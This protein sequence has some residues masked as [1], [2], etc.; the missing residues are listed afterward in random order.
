[1]RIAFTIILN[2]IHHLKH[3][4]YAEFLLDTF[5]YWIVV[6][7]GSDS[8]GDTSWCNKGV[9][10]QYCKDGGSIDGTREYLLEL[11]RKHKNL[12]LTLAPG[13]LWQN[14]TK[15][16]NV[17]AGVI[18]NITDHAFVWEIDADE[19]WTEPDIIAAEKS[20]LAQGAKTGTFL[21]NCFVGKNLL[22]LGE[23]GEGTGDPI[24]R[25]WDWRR[26]T[27]FSHEPPILTGGNGK[28]VLL[29]QR[30]D[31]YS[32]YFEKDVQFKNDWYTGH[33]NILEYWKQ[34]QKE[35][36]FPQ[37]ISRLIEGHWG[38]TKT[39]IYRRKNCG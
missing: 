14:K 38:K 30:F 27:F 4:D 6:E 22:A 8:T 32:Y 16:V 7:G 34:L 28:T 5:D 12:L 26:N 35:T 33:E 2:G 24:R 23:W 19:Q 39:M 37:P 20:M 9:P 10:E 1:M 3:N 11:K 13:K 15:M 31:H 25:L 17:A 36:E 29:F 21:C 18:N